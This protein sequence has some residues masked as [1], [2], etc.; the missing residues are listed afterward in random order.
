MN[1]LLKSLILFLYP[2]QCR[3]CGENLD[4][5]DGH[6]ICKSCWQEIEFIRKP[7]CETCGYPLG[8]LAALPDRIP[9]CDECPE[10][11][12][13][14][15]ARSVAVYD[16][17]VGEAF[18]LLKYHG[19]T[20]MAR[21]LADLMI[22]AMPVFFSME[23]YD[24]IVPVPLHKRRKRER[25]YNQVELIG[26]RLTRATGIPMEIHVLIKT[27]NTPPQVGLSYEE[28]LRN[29]RGHFDVSDPS[30]ITGKKIL[31][32]DDVFTT[33]TTASES[34]RVLSR[35]GKAKYVDV[36]TLLRVTKPK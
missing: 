26:R 23:D 19:K 24:C 36:F 20:V 32:I 2:A 27:V 11:P 5:S 34:A 22:E 4:P 21:P 3:Y 25:G 15:K 30:R 6:Y 18:R 31:L 35:K 7:Y 10:N 9:S 33:G 17:V 8:P 28:R 12:Q 16:S 13:F 14:R 29:V 1:A